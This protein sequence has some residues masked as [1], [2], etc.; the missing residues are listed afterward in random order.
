MPK[1]QYGGTLDAMN[2]F[3]INVYSD[4]SNMLLLCKFQLSSSIN[5]FCYMLSLGDFCSQNFATFTT[6]CDNY[7]FFTLTL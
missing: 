1:K 5:F 7:I 6:S 4:T 2:G 3:G